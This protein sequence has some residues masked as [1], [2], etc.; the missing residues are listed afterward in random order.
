MSTLT[1]SASGT[2]AEAECRQAVKEARRIVVKIGS[3]VLVQRTGRP[4]L[5][6]MKALVNDLARIH[7]SGRELIVVSSG[8]I[9]AGMEALDLKARPTNLP[10]LQMAAAIGQTRLMTRYDK[11]FA[12]RRA[13][14][15]QVLLT[16]DDLKDRRRHL[17]ARNTILT[18]LRHRVIPIVNENDVVAVEEIKFGDNDL[19]AALVALLVEADLLILLTVV[20]GLRR[21]VAGG[22]SRR[23]SFIDRLHPDIQQVVTGT[24]SPLSVGGMVTKIQSAM[25]VARN[26]TLALVANGRA[27]GALDRILRG[28]HVGTLIVDGDLAGRP[29][30][31][32]RKRWIAFYHK[33]HGTLVVDD[34]ARDALRN[35]GK[36]L[37]PIGIRA[38]GGSFD[39]GSVVNI[40][41]LDGVLIGR[42][43]VEYSSRDIELIKGRKTS[44]IAALLGAK[45][46][47]EVIHRDNMVLLQG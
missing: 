4:D 21:P 18:L 10:E 33:A 14:V 31:S 26:G 23:I 19:L 5:V 13:Q 47:D 7:H 46:Y 1:T 16:H 37:L 20:D 34:G 35:K 6:R 12:A 36:S 2:P 8:A 17:N 32:G 40:K 43:L 41:G 9:S 39:T 42:G 30:L 3:R 22:K 25:D 28:E 11:L 44:E 15:G 27:D 29:P 38:V 45:D 24:D